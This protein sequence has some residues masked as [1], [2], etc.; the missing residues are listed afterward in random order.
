MTLHPRDILRS[1]VFALVAG[2]ILWPPASELVYWTAVAALGDA[3]ILLV[4]GASVAV[5]FVFGVLT[6]VSPRSFAV[7]G[8]LT[9]LIGM[10]AF[11]ITLTPDSPV[12]FLLYGVIL[13]GMCIGVSST[14]LVT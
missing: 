4:L 1:A 12:H 10:S 9:Y 13:I 6:T 8:T 7:G 3:V 11:E 2:A 5:G 14:Q